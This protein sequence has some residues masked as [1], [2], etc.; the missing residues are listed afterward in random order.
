METMSMLPPT[1][2]TAAG[3]PQADLHDMIE[4]ISSELA[5]RPLLTRIVQYA[6]ELLGADRGTIGLVDDERNVIRT[7][8]AYRMP[9]DELGAEMP[10]GVGLAG[11]VFQAQQPIILNRYGEL[12]DPV[13]PALAEDAVIGLPIFW[14]GRMVAFFGIGAA[15]PRR[16]TA[17]DV[18]L[19]STLARHAAV[20]IDNAQMFDHTQR[21]LTETQLLYETSVRISTAMNVTGVIEAYLAQVATRDRYAC[22]VV[23]YEF[24]ADGRRVAVVVRGRWAP[25]E[26][27]SLANLR[28]PYSRDALDPLLDAGQTV[29][30]NDV[31]TDPRVPP[32]LRQIQTESGRPALAL[33][34][35]IA[36]R[37][38]IGLV[39]LSYPVV[40][41]WQESA[42]RPYQ[43]TAVQLAGAID[44]RRQQR[45]LQER[46]QQLAVLE[47]RQRLARELH[48]SVTQLIFSVTLIAQ[49]IAPAWRRDPAQGEER[50]RRLLELSQSALAEMRALL[51]ELRPSDGRPFTPEPITPGLKRLHREGL[52]AAL[53]LYLAEIA[54]D[55]L[56]VDVSTAGYSQAGDGNAS[57]LPP[58][59]EETLYR[60]G[61]EALNNVVKHARAGRVTINL[62]VDQA[63]ARLIITDDGQG[64]MAPENAND[65]PGRLG[66]KTMRERVEAVGGGLRL[67]SSP[68]AGT[69]VA[70][71]LPW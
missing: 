2:K 59:V 20:A 16:F 17:E 63:L 12:D 60:V 53:R 68:G 56:E 31:H 52:P 14:R 36:R 49:S 55:N 64:F 62:Y 18:A 67:T 43:A 54:G 13:Q 4:S 57:R 32:E 51:A 37:Q 44:S 22:S 46:N 11:A 48:D 42:L 23:L 66:L 21:A 58:G 34:P 65:L 50:V 9:P 26:G 1:A 69:A 61:Q 15:P 25:E 38:R 5:L 28:L 30:I 6:C 33:I 8:A 27:F 41:E 39:V 35:L 10:P 3:R 71:T 40:H 19:L 45:L 47:E 7:E 24:D 70:I 29:A